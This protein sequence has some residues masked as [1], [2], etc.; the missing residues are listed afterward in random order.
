M[1]GEPKTLYE[2]RQSVFI[3]LGFKEREM[4]AIGKVYGKFLKL[5]SLQKLA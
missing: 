5:I 3:Y 1:G 2:S 4:C